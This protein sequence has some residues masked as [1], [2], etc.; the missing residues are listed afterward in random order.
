MRSK[1]KLVLMI[2]FI[3]AGI[4]S[5]Q[6]EM[7]N[8]HL[9]SDSRTAF[10]QFKPASKINIMPVQISK[11]SIILAGAL[12]LLLP[13]AGE[14]YTGEYWRA[15]AFIAV[16]AAIVTTAIIYDKKGDDQTT[17]FENYAD[18]NWSVVRYAEWL[19][20]YHNANIQINPDATLPSWERVDWNELNSYENGSHKM[21]SHGEQQYYELIG[22]YWQYSAGWNDYT[23][24]ANN[25]QLSPNFNFYSHMRGEANDYYNV[26]SKAVIGI[27]INHFLSM[28]DA[29]WSSISFN[30]NLALNARVE[31]EQYARQIELVPT[32]N[33]KFN[34]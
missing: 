33:L 6:T 34:F 20:Q 5:A 23:A 4:L 12:S 21:P 16:E 8:G 18:E 28:I 7:F 10:E 14:I 13:G 32:I 24:G 26:A 27:Y 30:K 15:A 1:I 19:N 25:T 9:T 3:A 31:T 17:K 29:V 2:F 22:K 11:K